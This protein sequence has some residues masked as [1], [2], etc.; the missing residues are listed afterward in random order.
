LAAFGG[1]REIS[2]LNALAEG[3]LGGE[4]EKEAALARARAKG[5]KGA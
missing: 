4:A 1:T 5:F 2:G 3:A